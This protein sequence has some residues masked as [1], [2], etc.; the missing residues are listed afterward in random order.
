MAQVLVLHICKSSR[1]FLAVAWSLRSKRILLMSS[2]HSFSAMQ[3]L[4]SYLQFTMMQERL[5]NLMV[6]HVHKDC[7]WQMSLLASAS[8]DYK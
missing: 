8:V 2:E 3:H 6:L 5:N 4:K 1:K 7:M